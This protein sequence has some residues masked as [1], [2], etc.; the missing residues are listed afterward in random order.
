[1]SK[2]SKAA[3]L[4]YA[5]EKAG[6]ASELAR[7]LGV[8]RQAVAQWQAVPPRQARKVSELTGVPLA[9]ICPEFYKGITA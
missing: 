6:G 7:K 2:K 5:I 1:M 3:A 8:S 9:D 4:A